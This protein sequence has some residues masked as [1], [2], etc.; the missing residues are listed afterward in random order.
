MKS[1]EKTYNIQATLCSHIILRISWVYGLRNNNFLKTML[2][3]YNSRD[4]L[5]IINDQHGIP[6]WSRM[7]AEITAQIIAKN[8]L[9]PIQEVFHLGG[10]EST[11]WYHFA[12]AILALSDMQCLIKPITTEQYPLP[13][14][15][16]INSVLSATKLAQTFH[17]SLPDWQTMLKLC[18]ER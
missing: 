7:I 17:L 11:T 3:L 18:M 15:R 4:E 5:N 13:A 10:T 14:K 1:Y 12:K 6:M 9:N 16:P 2:T 8:A